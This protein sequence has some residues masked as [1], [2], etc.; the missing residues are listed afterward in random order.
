MLL[1]IGFHVIGI[2]LLLQD[3]IVSKV[4]GGFW[5]LLST[6]AFNYGLYKIVKEAFFIRDAQVNQV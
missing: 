2:V 5:L 3:S 4:I 1:Y 6:I